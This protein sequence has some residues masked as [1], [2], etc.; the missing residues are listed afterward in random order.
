MN[1]LAYFYLFFKKYSLKVIYKLALIKSIKPKIV[2]T[3][4]D[5]SINFYLC[6]K[7]LHKEI[8]FLAIQNANRSGFREISYFLEKNVVFPKN[9]KDLI[10]IPNFICFGE[11]EII[12]AKKENLKI[13]NFYNFGSVRISNF[14]C[15]LK[16]NKI[17]LKKNLFDICLVSEPMIDQNNDFKND[18]LENSYIDVVQYCIKF[19]ME[20]NLKFNFATKRLYNSK[21]LELEL[22]FYKNY[23]SK[24]QLEYLFSNMNKKMNIYS[25]YEALFQS[26][27]AV[28]W[29]STLL[30]DKIGLKEKILSCNFSSFK[31]WDFPIDGICSLRDKNYES[32]SE[33]L[34]LISSLTEKDYLEKLSKKPSFV[35]NF[36]KKNSL[37]EKTKKIIEKNF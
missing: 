21:Q 2:I 32:F 19:C 1:F 4:I 28:G 26:K 20:N 5:N 8:Y 35:M 25:S 6:A 9:Y 16:K 36:D 15:Y 23:L 34:K 27:I 33:R 17:D 11:Q 10:F 7:I 18:T 31:T 29:T 30:L 3:S 22:N 37:I 24:E 12:G 14:F 13:K